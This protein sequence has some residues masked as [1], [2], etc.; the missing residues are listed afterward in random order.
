MRLPRGILV[1]SSHVAETQGSS[2]RPR[3]GSLCVLAAHKGESVTWSFVFEQGLEVF[4][5]GATGARS[6]SALGTS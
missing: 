5:A 1:E 2:D 4:Q 3:E 6:G